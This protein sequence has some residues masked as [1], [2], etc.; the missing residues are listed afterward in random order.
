MGLEDVTLWI[1]GLLVLVNLLGQIQDLICK[2]LQ[3]V[4]IPGLSFSM[5]VENAYPIQE[6]FKLSRPGP[7]LGLVAMRL[8]YIG[9][10]A[11]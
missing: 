1:F 7:V 8:L 11:V 2:A 5:G 4:A 10:R 6:P 3:S 9:H